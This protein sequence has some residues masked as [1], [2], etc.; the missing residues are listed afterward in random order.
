MP[1]LNIDGIIPGSLLLP[2]DRRRRKR[3]AVRILVYAR[4]EGPADSADLHEVHDICE[5]GVCIQ[6]ST[7]LELKQAIKL[8]LD[9]SAS[10]TPIILP[11]EVVWSNPQGRAGIHFSEVSDDNRDELRKLLQSNESD[12]PAARESRPSAAHVPA[13]GKKSFSAQARDD[14]Q[15]L[16]ALS[17]SDFTSILTAL[18]AVKREVQV[19]GGDVE[20]IL[21]LLAMRMISFTGATGAA[22]AVAE[23]GE[24]ICKAAAGNDAPP[25]GTRVASESG[26][27]GQCIRSAQI[28]YCEDAEDDPRVNLEHCR[29]LGVRS[30]IAVPIHS[31]EPVV[32]IMEV[33]S[34]AP[35]AFGSNASLILQYLSQIA[36]GVLGQGRKSQSLPQEVPALQEHK[37]DQENDREAG[38]V[39]YGS[40][41]RSGILTASILTIGIAFAWLL[42][43]HSRWGAQSKIAA[44]TPAASSAKVPP[45]N[46]VAVGNL[47][48]HRKL[49]QQG[50]ATEQFAMGVHYATGDGVPQD[51]TE[52]VRWFL[53]AA[54]QG[55]VEAQGTLGAYYWAGRGGPQD[56]TRAY[57]WSLLAQAGGD[58]ASKYRVPILAS[59][60][61]HGQALAIQQQ[62]NNWLRDHEIHAS[63]SS[64]AD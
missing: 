30:I 18:A 46:P 31:G 5:D 56:L 50:D 54:Q 21:H 7:P 44:S 60:L 37:N 3:H 53:L 64:S 24:F 57:F 36:A 15:P 48:D 42:V 47:A 16:D 28:L 58:Q 29:A 22:I 52:A 32:G 51:Y 33:F 2:S 38:P 20:R 10:Q 13:D 35:Q 40:W 45:P 23:G 34:P 62:A 11:G 17:D 12:Q 49:A 19:F 8:S 9:C 26:F 63:P 1:S 6:I 25:V 14:S 4:V 41:V 27:S 61:T 43:P 39:A 55:H 59:R